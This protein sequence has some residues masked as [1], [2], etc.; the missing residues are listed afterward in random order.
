[1]NYDVIGIAQNAFQNANFVNLIISDSITT[2]GNNAFNGCPNLET[3]TLG[4]N[5]QTI[6]TNAFSGS[7]SLLK[8]I[9]LPESNNYFGL[10]TFVNDSTLV[11]T[12]S[13]DVPGFLHT[14]PSS[15]FTL[16]PILQITNPNLIIPNT[17][18]TGAQTVSVTGLTNS[19]FA[20]NTNIQNVVFPSSISTVPSSAFNGAS[21]LQEADLSHIVTVN[22]AAFQNT[23]L[24]KLTL[25]SSL[26]TIATGVFSNL[27]LTEINLPIDNANFVLI[28]QNGEKVDTISSAI[29]GFM[30]NKTDLPSTPGETIGIKQYVHLSTSEIIIPD[31]IDGHRVAYI[32]NPA[33][34]PVYDNIGSFSYAPVT[35]ITTGTYLTEI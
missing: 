22:S 14:K 20:N 6:S 27:N 29:P 3:I 31:Y 12:I 33:N 23:S 26:K 5:I 30:I 1:L 21:N 9:S 15:N 16:N 7:S 24:K 28:N 8:S 35:K 19:I 25:G 17:L 11:P 4:A 13:K 2:I 18:N 10:F 32:A 34:T